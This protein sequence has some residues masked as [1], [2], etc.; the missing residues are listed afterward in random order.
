MLEYIYNCVSSKYLVPDSI[1]PAIFR[2]LARIKKSSTVWIDHQLLSDIDDDSA[3]L[4]PAEF[5]IDDPT[6][7]ASSITDSRNK[8]TT[9]LAL[10]LTPSARAS[11]VSIL[12]SIPDREPSSPDTHYEISEESQSRHVEFFCQRLELYAAQDVVSA[13]AATVFIGAT[14]Q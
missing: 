1:F 3:Y 11:G 14:N 5:N 2:Q 10:R 13:S 6:S 8:A 7:S 9:T 4:T 12:R